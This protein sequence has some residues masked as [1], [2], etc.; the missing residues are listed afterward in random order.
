MYF[1][2]I[3]ERY[4]KEVYCF[5]LKLCKNQELAEEITQEYFM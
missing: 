4:F 5:S 1:E 2:E 3:Y